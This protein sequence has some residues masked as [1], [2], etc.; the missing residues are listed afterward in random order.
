MSM[1]PYTENGTHWTY[2]NRAELESLLEYARSQTGCKVSE[3][4]GSHMTKWVFV[5]PGGS[6]RVIAQQ[7][8]VSPR[9]QW[10][11]HQF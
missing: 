11:A 2:C 8:L 3:E 9:Q 5:T 6:R 4:K 10:V 7:T 1:S